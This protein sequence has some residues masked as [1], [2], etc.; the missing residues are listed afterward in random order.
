M[1]G[2]LASVCSEISRKS[3]P[4][5]SEIDPILELPRNWHVLLVYRD[6][7]LN[8][9]S[10]FLNVRQEQDFTIKFTKMSCQPSVFMGH[11]S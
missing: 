9:R 11:Y 5:V 3:P 4:A 6:L 8:Y 10:L 2:T 7:S 1:I